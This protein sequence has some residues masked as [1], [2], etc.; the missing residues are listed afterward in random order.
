MKTIKHNH[1]GSPERL[2]LTDVPQYSPSEDEVLIEVHAASVNPLEWRIVRA[3]PILVRF[4]E[5]FFKPKEWRL[6]NDVAGKIVGIGRD[7][8]EFKIGDDVFGSAKGSLAEF[9]CAKAN[10]IALKPNNMSFEKAAAVP[11]AGV[12]ALQ[13]LKLGNIKAGH[14]VLINGASGGVGSMAVQIATALG[15]HVTGVC[16]GSNAEFVKSIGAKETIDYKKHQ[17]TKMQNKYDLIIDTIANQ[18]FDSNIRVL[19]PGG[20]CVIVGFWTLPKLFSG[21]A[22]SRKAGSQIKHLTAQYKNKEDLEFLSELMTKGQLNPSI[23]RTYALD[24]VS[25]ALL[26]LESKRARGKVVIKVI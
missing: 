20:I 23:D 19:S 9:A 11:V 16:S 13:A 24:D 3:A 17:Y 2:E 7:V 4:S 10:Q 8:T 15:A 25:K 14:K 26:Y 1:Y 21:L 18:S 6:G 5:G 22:R 12:T